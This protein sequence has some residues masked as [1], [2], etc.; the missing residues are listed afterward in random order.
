MGG[1]RIGGKL[2][3]PLKGGVTLLTLYLRFATVGKYQK[4]VSLT[5]LPQQAKEP[6]NA[7]RQQ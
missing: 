1:A 5:L 3:T 7:P 2:V 6:T 4:R